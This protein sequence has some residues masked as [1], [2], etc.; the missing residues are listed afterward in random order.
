[1]FDK[2]KQL[3]QLKSLQNEIA[4][5]RFVV[6][7]G[8]VRVVVSGAMMVEDVSLGSDLDAVKQ[9]DLVKKC[10]NSALKKAQFAAAQKMAGM[11][12]GL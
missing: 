10:T 5:E 11:N 4:K 7:E 12:L 9:A 2:F 8:G 3:A 1:M 6:E